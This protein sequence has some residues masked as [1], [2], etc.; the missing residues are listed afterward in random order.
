MALIGWL[1]LIIL[2]TL[3]VASLLVVLCRPRLP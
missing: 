3:A 1:D 2:G